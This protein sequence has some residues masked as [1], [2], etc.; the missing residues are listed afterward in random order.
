[1]HRRYAPDDIC[2]ADSQPHKRPYRRVG[3]T[4]CFNSYRRRHRERVYEKCYQSLAV[5]SCKE[6]SLVLFSR[7][8]Q[9]FHLHPSDPFGSCILPFLTTVCPR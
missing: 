9:H 8:R 2:T 3:E 4:L 7:Q 6:V 1:M 5:N